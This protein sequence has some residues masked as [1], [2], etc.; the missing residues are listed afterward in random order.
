[1]V[2][3]GQTAAKSMQPCGPLC[4]TPHSHTSMQAELQQVAEA[5]RQSTKQLCRNL[6]DNPNVAENM[7]KVASE[8][9]GLQ[10]LIVNTLN[11]LDVFKKIQPMVESVMAQEAAEVQMKKTIEHERTTT[12]AVRQLRND[13]RDEKIDHEEKVQYIP[14]TRHFVF[15]CLPAYAGHV[16]SQLIHF[17]ACS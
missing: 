12:A 17:W 1:M 2:G 7:A 16:E 9:Q 10:L 3:P 6:K 14:D 11:E 4:G 15:A 8:R 5:L 13:L